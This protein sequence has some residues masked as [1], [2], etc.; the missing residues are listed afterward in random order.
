MKNFNDSWI[1]QAN[2]DFDQFFIFIVILFAIPA[3]VII[4]GLFLQFIGVL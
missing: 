1:Q 4:I 2:K 3:V